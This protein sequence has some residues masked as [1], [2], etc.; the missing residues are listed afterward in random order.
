MSGTKILMAV[1]ILGMSSF[2]SSVYGESSEAD[3]GAMVF[4]LQEFESEDGA[5]FYGFTC[6]NEKVFDSK[7]KCVFI[8]HTYSEHVYEKSTAAKTPA[9]KI[10]YELDDVRPSLELRCRMAEDDKR[11]LS[12]A[13]IIKSKRESL[14][15]S[16]KVNQGLCGCLKSKKLGACLE[17]N[18]EAPPGGS[19]SFVAK[20]SDVELVKQKDGSWTAK[21]E[22]DGCGLSYDL[23][24]EPDVYPFFGGKKSLLTVVPQKIEGQFAEIEYCQKLAEK[25]VA[26]QSYSQGVKLPCKYISVHAQ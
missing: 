13:N 12:A 5:S 21:V 2:A 6:P 20:S 22:A 1:L 25:K 8:T 23:R 3:E 24:I 9:K 10:T 14:E 11:A 19:C 18:K 16:L 17:K 4:G 15:E 26:P 7:R